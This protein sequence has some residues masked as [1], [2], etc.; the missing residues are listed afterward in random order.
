M[1]KPGL[2]TKVSHKRLHEGSTYDVAAVRIRAID[3]NGNLL[4]F[5]QEPIKVEA[6]GPIQIIGGDVISLK[7]GMGGLYIKTIGE[8]GKAKVRLVNPQCETVEL[9]FEIA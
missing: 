4:P 9:D 1:R 7:G 5:Y 6:E 2:E 3:E 8:K